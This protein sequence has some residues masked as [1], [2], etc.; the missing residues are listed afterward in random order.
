MS[1]EKE[2]RQ[3]VRARTGKTIQNARIKRNLSID[4]CAETAK[5]SRDHF[6]MIEMG[7]ADFASDDDVWNLFSMLDKISDYEVKYKCNFKKLDERNFGK[8]LK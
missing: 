4:F 2:K 5:V 7:K 8:H 3:A 6:E 1:K